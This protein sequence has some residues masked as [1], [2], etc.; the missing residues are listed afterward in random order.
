MTKNQKN[1][2]VFYLKSNPNPQILKWIKEKFGEEN[3]INLGA[4]K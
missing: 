1:L 2:V 3:V 4:E